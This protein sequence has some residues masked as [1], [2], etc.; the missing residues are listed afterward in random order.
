[1]L[2]GN[3]KLDTKNYILLKEGQGFKRKNNMVLQ[4]FSRISI[5]NM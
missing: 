2:D 1:M 4:R 5:D 3:T